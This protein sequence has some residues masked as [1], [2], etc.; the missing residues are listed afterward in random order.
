MAFNSRGV[1]PA[2]FNWADYFDKPLT[3]EPDPPLSVEQLREEE[4]KLTLST[5][6]QG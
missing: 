5:V 4:K 2:G 6:N 3:P 1:D